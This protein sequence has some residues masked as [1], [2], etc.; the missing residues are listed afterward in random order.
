MVFCLVVVAGE[1]IGL[2][3]FQPH[4]GQFGPSIQDRLESLDGSTRH[5]ELHL[6]AAEQEEPLDRFLLVGGSGLLEECARV[7]KPA[8]PDEHPGGLNV[9]EFGWWPDCPGNGVG[10]RAGRDQERER[11]RGAGNAEQTE[12]SAY[13][14]LPWN[15]PDIT[16]RSSSRLALSTPPTSSAAGP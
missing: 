3:E 6:D 9:G 1:V 14:F 7:L 2:R 16:R 13:C 12:Q 10:A 11:E 5:A 4:P 15:A 8:G